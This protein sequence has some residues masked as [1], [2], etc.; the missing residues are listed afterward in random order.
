MNMRPPEFA[1][2][3]ALAR[4]KLPAERTNVGL[5]SPMVFPYLYLA[6]RL[7]HLLEARRQRVLG[8]PWRALS[9][10]ARA[11]GT[12]VRATSARCEGR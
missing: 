3:Y 10:A 5:F 11:S 8:R 1:K 6:L 9:R 2:R 12:A 7:L 4:A